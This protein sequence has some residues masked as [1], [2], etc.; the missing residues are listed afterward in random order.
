[1]SSLVRKILLMKLPASL[2]FQRS[3][4]LGCV[5]NSN[6]DG[7]FSKLLMVRKIDPGHDS[8]S[9]LLSASEVIY[10]MQ[11]HDVKPDSIE[12]YLDN[13]EKY[14]KIAANK[15]DGAELVGSWSVEIGSQDQFIH[16]WRYKH[17]YNHAHEFL[18]LR[19]TDNDLKSLIKD[20]I[21][22]IRHRENQFMLS[23]S[24]W[25]HPQPKEGSNMYEMRSYVLKPGTMIEW[26]NNWARGVTYRKESAVAGF[27]SQIGQL[28]MV[29]H[30][31]SYKN[32]QMR[33]D[34]RDAAWRKPGWDECVA[35]TVPLIRKMESRWM[36]PTKFSPIQ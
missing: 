7:W 14:A 1:M 10:E 29:H 2:T 20:R 3:L 6:N 13:Y 28:Y 34:V 32:L 11:T 33:K 12:P 30:I 26:G 27:F 8:H 19:H 21:P 35:H 5:N 36:K 22:F 31:W 18:E 23:F 17:G 24:F 9:R 4:W 25:G 15:S 16:V